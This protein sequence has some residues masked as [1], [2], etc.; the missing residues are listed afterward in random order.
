[1]YTNLGTKN[2]LH[3]SSDEFDCVLCPKSHQQSRIPPSNQ[4]LIFDVPSAAS[5]QKLIVVITQTFIVISDAPRVVIIA[6]AF[7]DI[8]KGV[9]CVAS[10][11]PKPE[12]KECRKRRPN[13]ILHRL[14][15]RSADDVE[16]TVGVFSR[17]IE[18]MSTHRGPHPHQTQY[19]H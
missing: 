1:M 18:T 3:V 6:Q 12:V 5:S 19:R 16:D 8:E 7:V 13:H 15:R 2:C 4:L 17:T 9:P 10:S 14:V 11:L